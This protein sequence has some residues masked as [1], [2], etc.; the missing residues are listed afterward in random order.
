MIK[1]YLSCISLNL[2]GLLDKGKRQT[3]L[4]WLKLQKA[5]IVFLQETHITSATAPLI[6]KEW[7]DYTV[8]SYG[9]NVSRGVSIMFN[10]SAANN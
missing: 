8:H 4:H 5:A 3:I 10:M 1:Q 9:S 6:D 7:D 2:K